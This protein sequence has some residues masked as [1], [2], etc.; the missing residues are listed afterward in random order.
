MKIYVVI[1]KKEIFSS[2]LLL[3]AGVVDSRQDWQGK[4]SECAFRNWFIAHVVCGVMRG[5]TISPAGKPLVSISV[6]LVAL[7]LL[8]K[9]AEPRLA[10]KS[11]GVSAFVGPGITEILQNTR[12]R[13][14]GFLPWVHAHPI[15]APIINTRPPRVLDVP[16]DTTM[17]AD[18]KISG[19]FYGIQREVWW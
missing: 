16:E 4:Q 8:L 5:K 3:L 9:V 18:S 10:G 19:G 7:R 11:P 1:I 17:P 2:P 13:K 14:I 15:E 6:S 12:R